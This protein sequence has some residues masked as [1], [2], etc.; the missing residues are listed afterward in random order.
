M[1]W[2]TAYPPGLSDANSL[3]IMENVQ[4]TREGAARVRPGLRSYLRVKSQWPLVGSHEVFYM[5]NGKAYLVAV[6]ETVDAGTADEREIIGFRAIVDVSSSPDDARDL[7]MLPLND[8]RV[9]FTIDNDDIHDL[10]FSSAATYVRYLQIDNKIF[11]LADTSEPMIMFWVGSARKA[12][13]LQGLAR[14]EWNTAD[15][16]TVMHPDDAWVG[17]APGTGA[18]RTNLCIN[19]DFETNL[20]H[21]EAGTSLTSVSRSTALHASGSRSLA[22]QSLPAVMNWARS[23]LHSVSTTGLSGWAIAV[24]VNRISVEG[25]SMRIHAAR[26]ATDSFGYAMSD[27]LPVPSGEKFRFAFDLTDSENAKAW[28]TAV[29]FFRSNGDQIGETTPMGGNTNLT[30][31]RKYSKI[32]TIPTQATAMRVLIGVRPTSSTVNAKLDVKN[33]TLNEDNVSTAALDG[34]DGAEHYWEGAVNNSRSLYHPPQDIWVDSSKYVATP[35]SYRMGAAVHGTAGKTLQVQARAY[36]A[37]D[38]LLTSETTTAT[39]TAA[40]QRIVAP[41]LTAPAGTTRV[42]VRVIMRDAARDSRLHVDSVLVERS[43]AAGDYFSGAT[44]NT[45]LLKRVWTGAAHAST[46]TEELL[47]KP[48]LSSETPSEFT[49]VSNNDALNTYSVGFFYTLSN[50]IGESAASQVTIV[51]VQRPWTSWQW[52]NSAGAATLD[53]VLCVDQLVARMPQAVFDAAVASKARHWTLYAYTWG[54]NDV[55]PV[56]AF[57]IDEIDL[58]NEPAYAED[59]WARMTPQ[60]V[61][62]QD[63][64]PLVP[65]QSTRYDS[66]DPSKGSQGL[67]AADR[68][69]LVGD[70]DDPARITWSSGA[71]GDYHNFSPLLGGGTKQLTSGNLYLTANVQLWQNPQSVDTLTVL[72]L[73]DDGRSNAYYMSPTTI[74]TLSESIQVM[75]FE[76]VTSMRGTIS[77]YGCE[78]VNN[79]LFRPTHHALLKSTANNYNITTKSVSDEIANVWR[80]LQNPHRI[81]SSNLDNRIYYLVHNIFGAPLE[82]HCRGNEVWV[83]DTASKTPT[84]SRWLVQGASLRAMDIDDVVMMSIVRPEGIFVFSEDR[85]TDEVFD[86][87]TGEPVRRNIPWYLETNTQGANRAHDAWANLQQANVIL[88]NF[89]GQLRYGIRGKDVNGMDIDMEKVVLSSAP[90]P[91]GVATPE[92]EDRFLMPTL[93]P[94]DREDYF[95]VRKMMKEWFFFA[96]SIDDSDDSEEPKPRFSGGQISAV[97]YRYTPVT[98]NVGYEYGSVETFE[99]AGREDARAVTD[100]GTPQPYIDMSRP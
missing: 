67:V 90:P 66:S 2:S 72:N 41:V 3:R 31:E 16:L 10:S 4:V 44:G 8:P 38:T 39:G 64:D 32:F 12:K 52:K 7:Q 83:L 88:G 9:G 93:N 76:E 50:E 89:L 15:K 36:N 14:P 47:G 100:S 81:V 19:P 86:S 61:A 80:I 11:A 69:I 62:I 46:S 42:N 45:A 96:G 94:T 24:R 79:G 73:G 33:V 99:Y 68:L 63:V 71:P 87:E 34:N 29:R 59:G 84:W 20:D 13:K 26:Q 30:K 5:P 92:L 54:P 1:G 22:A 49:L 56:T 70:Q 21:W 98:V 97:Q 65:T 17:N 43:G 48:A 37:S 23:P 28:G 57:R 95:L 25:S 74:T 27:K 53:P 55:P 78:V 6:R 51:K 91:D 58:T 77:P 82:A 18:I 60:L 85:Y 40:W 75:G 35:G